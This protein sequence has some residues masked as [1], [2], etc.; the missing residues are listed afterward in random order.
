MGQTPG[1]ATSNTANP[2]QGLMGL[3]GAGAVPGSNTGAT[4]NQVSGPTGNTAGPMGMIMGPA[5]SLLSSLQG[6][7]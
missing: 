5:T 6:N 2:V 7:R 1:A 3:L 4:Q